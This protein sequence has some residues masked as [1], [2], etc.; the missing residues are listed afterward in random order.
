[1]LTFI[2]GWGVFWLLL[3]AVVAGAAYLVRSDSML[4]TGIIGAIVSVI[5][6]IAVGIANLV[7]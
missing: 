7:T 3:W 5:Y 2:V 6:L 4:F 1:M